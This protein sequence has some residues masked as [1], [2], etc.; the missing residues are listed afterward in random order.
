MKQFF[1]DELEAATKALIP[2][3]MVWGRVG[4]NNLG[5]TCFMSSALQCM[6]HVTPLT[7]F[8]LSNRFI[9]DKNENNINGTGGKVADAYAALMKDLW[10][11]G[12]QYSSISPTNIKR[13]IELFAPRFYGVQQQDSAE[14]LAY[15]LDAL[16]EDLNRI[17]NP[18]YVQL[19]DVDRGKKLA[20]CGAETWDALCLRNS[21]FVFENFYG[22]Y[23]STCICPKCEEKSVTFDSFNHITLEIP[24]VA[25]LETDV[26]VIHEP[27]K[28]DPKLPVKYHVSVQESATVLDLKSSLSAMSG[29]PASRLRI[30][31]VDL[32]LCNIAN[33]YRYVHF[34]VLVSV[35]SFL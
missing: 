13:A 17:R 23:K 28:E 2:D 21:S 6:S 24:R 30:C 14:F 9:S 26:L 5:N 35:R 25:K 12:H 1:A 20:I 32:G 27:G 7:R 29:I 3:M 31:S 16:H 10:M 11:G 34:S 15:L 8:F 4:L 33:L 19:P 18:P 22:L